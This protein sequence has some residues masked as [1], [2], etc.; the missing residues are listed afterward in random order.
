MD[1]RFQVPSSSGA[2]GVAADALLVVVTAASAEAGLEKPLA[3]LLKDA[4]AHGDIEL[5]GGRALYLHRPAGV[6]AP[7]LAFA[8]AADGTA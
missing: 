3:A 4:V 2:A 7:R 8:V 1:F 5:K 6:K